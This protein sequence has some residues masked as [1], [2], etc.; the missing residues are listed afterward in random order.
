MKVRA[1]IADDEPLARAGLRAMLGE[2]DWVSCVGET[3]NGPETV[4]AVNRLRPELLFLDIQMPGMSGIEVLKRVECQPFVVFTTA[5]AQHAVAAF[6]LGALDYLLKPFGAE[7]FN[8]AMER[9]RSGL[10]EPGAV[11]PQ[12]RLSEALRNGPMSRIFVRSGRAIIPVPVAS[13]LWFE[14]DGDY[15]T[16][17]TRE[18]RYIVHLSLSRLEARLDAAR[19]VRIHRTHIVNLEHVVAFRPQGKGQLVAELSNGVRLPVSRSRAADIRA[20]G[21]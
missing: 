8:A 13:V 20:L 21:R 10:G 16:V 12:D 2:L 9:V 1:L 6:A 18:N 15:V 19:F 11:P 7:R 14:A 17:T 5:F 4:D 3:A